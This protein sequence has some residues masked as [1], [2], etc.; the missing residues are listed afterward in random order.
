MVGN[1]SDNPGIPI[2][3]GPELA[4]LYQAS[5]C[6]DVGKGARLDFTIYGGVDI[7]IPV[8]S[9]VK[10]DVVWAIYSV[11]DIFYYYPAFSRG[12]MYPASIV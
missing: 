8:T 4:A 11:D 12:I 7:S 9:L 10:G 3:N 1:E 2:V 6:V 5:A